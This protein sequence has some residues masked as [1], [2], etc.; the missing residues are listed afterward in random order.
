MSTKH[1][2]RREGAGR[3]ILRMLVRDGLSDPRPEES[4]GIAVSPREE[5][6]WEPG[7]Q[8]GGHGER[9]DLPIQGGSGRYLGR[10]PGLVSVTP[11]SGSQ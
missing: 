10:G 8:V 5:E 9:A 1:K 2:L 6:H 4:T 11:A 7:Q 3:A